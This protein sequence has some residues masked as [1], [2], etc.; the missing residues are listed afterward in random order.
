MIFRFLWATDIFLVRIK[1]LNI[2]VNSKVMHTVYSPS[3]EDA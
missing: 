3:E 2:F 1:Y